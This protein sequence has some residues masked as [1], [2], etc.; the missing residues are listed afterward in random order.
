MSLTLSRPVRRALLALHI[1]CGVG[2]MGLD[3]GLLVLVVAGATSDSGAT[4]AAAYTS[5]RLVV[6]GVVS[7]L[8]TGMLV[9][10]VLL[11]VGTRWRL[12]EWTWVLTKLVI[13]V[14]LTALVYLALVPTALA[15]PRELAG[16][17]EQVRD[18]VGRASSDLV[19]PPVVSFTL[20]GVALVLALWKPGGR[21]RW[22]RRRQ[23]E[24][25]GVPTP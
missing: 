20:L 14:V 22:G 13:G 19:Y 6:P 25:A 15:I 24:V 17:A 4:A 11:G 5:L 2:W 3:L 21:T 8:A 7:A 10:G 9:T 1:L 16:T 18:A 23:A 12:T